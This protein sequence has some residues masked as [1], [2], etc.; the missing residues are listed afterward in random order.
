M[1]DIFKYISGEKEYGTLIVTLPGKQPIHIYTINRNE[2]E[3]HINKF[4]LYYETILK[5]MNKSADKIK[6][7]L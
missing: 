1:A 7:S 6:K 4:I 3:R 2:V 5:D